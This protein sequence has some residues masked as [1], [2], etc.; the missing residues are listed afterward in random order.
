MPAVKRRR[1]K[2]PPRPVVLNWTRI[3]LGAG[4][5]ESFFVE[6]HLEKVVFEDHVPFKVLAS[7]PTGAGN[8]TKRAALAE[9]VIKMPKVYSVRRPR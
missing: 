1:R 5:N 2:D 3:D 8:D 4:E 7:V 9:A 6:F